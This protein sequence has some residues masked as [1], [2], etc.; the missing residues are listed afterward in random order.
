MNA[1]VR[2]LLSTPQPLQVS[3][4][5]ITAGTMSTMKEAAE[6]HLL[7]SLRIGLIKFKIFLLVQGLGL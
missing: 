7:F 1:G 4:P 6:S 2:E 3:I 5:G